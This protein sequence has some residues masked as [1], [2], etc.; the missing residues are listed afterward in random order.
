MG[1][2]S[3]KDK[4]KAQ[5]NAWSLPSLSPYVKNLSHS[6]SGEHVE[7]TTKKL[8]NTLTGTYRSHSALLY[9]A[10]R[11][12]DAIISK[13]MDEISINT[14]P[15]PLQHKQTL[16]IDGGR[17]AYISPATYNQVLENTVKEIKQRHTSYLVCIG[18]FDQL[19]ESESGRR[20]LYLENILLPLLSSGIIQ[21][22]CEIPVDIYNQQKNYSPSLRQRLY[23][24]VIDALERQKAYELLQTLKNNFESYYHHKVENPY[25]NLARGE[26]SILNPEHCN[27]II[28]LAR[29][30]WKSQQV[31]Y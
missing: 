6:N 17:L 11:N 29:K 30:T 7:Q 12:F 23:P 24:V 10:D 9:Q 15:Q 22:L 20:V 4:V 16:V 18:D 19:M 27:E 13:L 28:N 2:F 1:I 14:V 26:Y 5:Y 25:D 31:A 8:I 21:L 3:K